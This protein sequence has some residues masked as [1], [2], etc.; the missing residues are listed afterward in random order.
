MTFTNPWA[1]D[2]AIGRTPAGGGSSTPPVLQGQGQTAA[3]SAINQLGSQAALGV[4]A[5]QAGYALDYQQ[6]A[7][8][9]DQLAQTDAYTQAMSGYQGSQLQLAGEKIGLQQQGQQIQ[10]GA[11]V[12][13][14]G[15]ER[16]QYGLQQQ[17]YPEQYAQAAL[18]YG[19]NQQ[20]LQGQEAASGTLNSGG[21]K[22][23]QQ[24][25]FANYGWQQQDIARA[26]G[27]SQ[28]GQKS[29]EIG[30]GAQQQQAGLA[31]KNLS[32][33]A[34]ANGLSEQ[35]LNDQLT[36]SLAQNKQAGIQSTGQLLAQ[37]GNL[38][39]GDVSTEAAA[40]L[41][42]GYGAGVNFAAGGHP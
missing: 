39:A 16:Q 15:I 7:S 23:Q 13:Q 20:N 22:Q 40:L 11:N 3:Q 34:Q 18:Q 9:G 6:L 4:A 26:Q 41:P 36:Y 27:L 24:N 42:I 19:T 21:S 17:Q 38:A 32:L 5:D 29:E 25:L 37:M 1:A 31:Q 2:A 8:Q 10:T 28:L 12:A 14:Q 35:Q 30:Y 33:A